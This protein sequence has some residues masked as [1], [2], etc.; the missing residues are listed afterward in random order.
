MLHKP[1]QY[2]SKYAEPFQDNSVVAAYRYRPP[3]PKAVFT[4][5]ADLMTEAPRRVLD[6]GCGTGNIARNL[7]AY[8]E[9][10]DAVD[11][12]EPMIAVGKQLPNGNH[13]AAHWLYGP[14]EEVVSS[15]PRQSSSAN[16]LMTTSSRTIPAVAFHENE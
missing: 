13:R 11:F 15:G 5:L 16:R 1:V 4:I 12:W 2:D 3:Y 6:V 9:H 10:I 14:I 8:A 7:V